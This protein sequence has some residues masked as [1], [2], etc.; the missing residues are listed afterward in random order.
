MP[1]IYV[2]PFDYYSFAD[3]YYMISQTK[4]I[5]LN[6][7]VYREQSIFLESG[8]S[9]N[10]LLTWIVT[11]GIAGSLLILY[12]FIRKLRNSKTMIQ[13]FYF[14]IA[15]ILLNMTEP[16]MLTPLVIYILANEY[17]LIS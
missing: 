8:E 14:L 13:D 9:S 4:V 5:F 7:T 2:E 15:F 12:P 17:S 16:L 1:V 6:Q 3:I 11:T 10:G